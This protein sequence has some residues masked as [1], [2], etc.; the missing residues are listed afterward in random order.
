MEEILWTERYR[1]TRIKDAILPERYKSMFDKMITT[2]SIPNLLLS[3]KAGLGKTTI[4]R[5]MCDQMNCSYLMIN[6]SLDGTKDTLRN[7]IKDFASSM[8]MTGVRKFVI[9][10]EADGLTHNMQ[11]ALR[12]FMEEYS[13][14][15]GFILTCNKPH[16]IIPELHSRCTVVDFDIQSNERADILKKTAKRIFTILDKEKVEYDKR[17]VV[18]LINKHFPDIRKVLND[19]QRY[20]VAGKIDSGIL[21][22]FDK[23]LLTR[24]MT[25]MKE[26]KL[27]DIRKFVSETDMDGQDIYN[28]LYEVASEYFTPSSAASLVVLLSKYQDM[29]TRAP[30]PEITLC[31]ALLEISASLEWK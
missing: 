19:L 29:S 5:A 25:M 2:G 4:A 30:N 3:G 16:K 9:L 8:S 28:K 20:S 17:T 14:N 24:L 18:A 10:D 6:G 31:A 23:T 11:P 21:I 12:N 27:M 15:C 7:E 13:R 22:D 1:P 26:R